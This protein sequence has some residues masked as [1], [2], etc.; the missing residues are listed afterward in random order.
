MD[1]APQSLLCFLCRPV[2]GRER[3]SLSP[4]PLL[5][6]LPSQGS[7]CTIC[8][9]TC[10][11]GSQHCEARCMPLSP[12]SANT[13]WTWVISDF[14]SLCATCPMLLTASPQSSPAA[15]PLGDKHPNKSQTSWLDHSNILFKIIIRK[16][17]WWR[18]LL[19]FLLWK[20]ARYTKSPQAGLWQLIALLFSL[21]GWPMT[22]TLAQ[23][24]L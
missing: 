13:E 18:T 24:C 10:A 17:T 3:S 1:P 9:V 4:S 20:G 2:Q 8:V 14:S 12:I 23:L 22:L 19:L 15:S 21:E 16:I 5:C 7:S 6:L 11:A